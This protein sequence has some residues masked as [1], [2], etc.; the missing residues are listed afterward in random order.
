[1]YFVFV[2]DSLVRVQDV[3]G[4][5]G[6]ITLLF[7]DRVLS[8]PANGGANARVAVGTDKSFNCAPLFRRVIRAKSRVFCCKFARRV[9]ASLASFQGEPLIATWVSEFPRWRSFHEY[10]A[11]HFLGGGNF[12]Q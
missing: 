5:A 10:R 1:M 4:A 11:C 6:M 2:F 8:R 12:R 9:R 3:S 7:C